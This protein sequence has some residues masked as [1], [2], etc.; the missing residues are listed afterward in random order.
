MGYWSNLWDA[1]LGR[2][3]SVVIPMYTR[4]VPVAESEKLP[5]E[6]VAEAAPITEE[7]RK[8][9]YGSSL[10]VEHS[11]GGFTPLPL[12][13]R[14]TI[15]QTIETLSSNPKDIET[16]CGLQPNQ[17]KYVVRAYSIDK[18]W[19]QTV[20]LNTLVEKK[21]V[22]MLY[23]ILKQCN[24]YAVTAR[25]FGINYDTMMGYLDIMDPL[26]KREAEQFTVFPDNSPAVRLGVFV[27]GLSDDQLA[28]LLRIFRKIK[29]VNSLRFVIPMYS[30]IKSS[31]VSKKLFALWD[32]AVKE[33]SRRENDKS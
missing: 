11:F 18:K 32:Y 3:P 17:A 1:L 16:V 33:E 30:E 8:K 25:L 6:L 22:Q 26:E 4:T 19:A 24:N 2:K 21:D 29:R 7:E 20:E 12:I 13:Q 14:Q 9:I 5:P 15:A 31:N 23:F 10:S 27:K 28:N